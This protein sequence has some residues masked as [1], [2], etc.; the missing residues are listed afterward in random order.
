MVCGA[1]ILG[2]LIRHY[3]KIG[4]FPAPPPPYIGMSG[5]TLAAAMDR[6]T[7]LVDLKK[8][9]GVCSIQARMMI[10]TQEI[11]ESVVGLDIYDFGAEVVGGKKCTQ[12]E[13][14]AGKGLMP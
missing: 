3:D 12:A 4:I 14:L 10:R 6:L 5:R 9:H 2:S 11:L 1:A 7:C 13:A 8:G